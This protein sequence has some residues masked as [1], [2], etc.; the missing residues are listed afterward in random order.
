MIKRFWKWGVKTF[1]N[2]KF[3]TFAVIGVI[4]TLIH[5]GTLWVMYKIFDAANILQLDSQETI[6]VLLANTI[7]FTVASV[8][9]Y[10]ANNKFTFGNDKSNW[11]EFWETIL[12]FL[13]RL[14]I[15]QLLTWLFVAIF[16]AMHLGSI[17]IDYVGPFGASIIMIPL[18]YLVLDRVLGKKKL[19][20]K[21]EE[22]KEDNKE[23]NE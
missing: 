21:I 15:T 14:G 13:A 9:S 11:K 4:N 3:I 17:W 10:F 8:F 12:V 16:N 7:A 18:T 23:V 1:L 5:L 2:K 22:I 6:S 20:E 19:E